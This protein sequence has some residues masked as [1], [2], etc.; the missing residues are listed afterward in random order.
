MSDI[1]LGPNGIQMFPRGMAHL[2]R[3]FYETAHEFTVGVSRGELVEPIKYPSAV[4]VLLAACLE[5]YRSEFLALY[6]E[7]EPARF[8]KQSA[9]LERERDPTERWYRTPLLF[10]AATFDRGREPF[11]SYRHL[12]A[13]RNALVHYS[14][15]FR[16]PDEYPSNTI[17]ELKAFYA[18]SN[19]GNADWTTQVLNLE[20]ARW[21]CRTAKAMVLGL[22]AIVGGND[23]SAWP[24][25]W[26]DPP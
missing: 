5:A 16:A 3:T 2:S 7:A 12:V 23:M 13:L 8:E 25:P 6:R 20:C 14:P 22:H 1:V 9:E 4:V 24:Y 26:P 21:G 18:F 11:Q 17:R 19:E 10:G 15:R